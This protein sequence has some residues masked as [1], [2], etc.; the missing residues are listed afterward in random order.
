MVMSLFV[1][2]FEFSI[3]GPLER[4]PFPNEKP[5]LKENGTW[6]QIGL[7]RGT[8]P[9]FSWHVFPSGL[10]ISIFG[11]GKV[12]IPAEQIK[13]LSEETGLKFF[14]GRYILKHSS[15]ELL[16]PVYLPNSRL[17]EALKVFLLKSE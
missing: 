5:V 2:A 7:F 1:F 3:F 14:K 4:S 12:F 10:G 13:G 6:G 8:F 15:P 17:F 16:N 11:I 9:F